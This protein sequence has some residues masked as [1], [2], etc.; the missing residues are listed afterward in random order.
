MKDVA[1]FFC[2]MAI[3]DK[4]GNIKYLAEGICEW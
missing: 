1:R 2:A 4:K 3:S